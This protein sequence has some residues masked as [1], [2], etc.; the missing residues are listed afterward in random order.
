[1]VHNQYKNNCIGRGRILML[2][3]NSWEKMIKYIIILTLP[4]LIITGCARWP[5]EPNGGGTGQKQLTIKVEINKNGTINTD[6]GYYYI[7]FDTREDASFPPDEDIDNWEDG[8]Y[9]IRLDDFG[10]YLGEV[11]NDSEEYIRDIPTA[12]TNF[13][14]TVDLAKLGN[15][16]EIFMNV[17]TTDLDNNTYDALDTDFYIE[18][19]LIFPKTET[20]FIQD[21]TGGAD[22]DI[23]QVE[24]TILVP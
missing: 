16:E 5:E 2:Y 14:V 20:D 15:P 21:S 19:D 17:I 10:F 3:I 24:T 4:V 22:F 13:Q 12:E 11:G 1:M 9:Y 18:T 8:Y 7:V 23:V 6:D